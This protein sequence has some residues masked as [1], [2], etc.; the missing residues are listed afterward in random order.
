[1]P[2]LS[3]RRF[4]LALAGSL[5][6]NEYV[7]GN[8][9]LAETESRFQIT[10]LEL[11]QLEGH[12]ERESGVNRQPQVNPLDVYDNLRSAPYADKPSGKKSFPYCRLQLLRGT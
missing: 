8:E 7:K 3:R 12:Y 10:D 4:G 6:G 5:A 2:F 1:M 11:I 9:Y